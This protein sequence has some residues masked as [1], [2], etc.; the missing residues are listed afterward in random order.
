M[1]TGAVTWKNQSGDLK[2]S[3]NVKRKADGEKRVSTYM[4]SLY[5]TIQNIDHYSNKLNFNVSLKV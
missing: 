4:G 3:S 2:D 5:E 1:D